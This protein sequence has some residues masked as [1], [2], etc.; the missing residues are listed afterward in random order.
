MGWRP[1]WGAR[2]PRL[3]RWAAILLPFVLAARAMLLVLIHFLSGRPTD[4]SAPRRVLTIR[5][6][7]LP[8]G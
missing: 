3:V 4:P 8:P 5:V 2:H 1:S 7:A 6:D